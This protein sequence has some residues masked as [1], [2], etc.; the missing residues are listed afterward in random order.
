MLSASL[1][2]DSV[3]LMIVGTSLTQWTSLWRKLTPVVRI[4]CQDKLST[5]FVKTKIFKPLIKNRRGKENT[6]F[7]IQHSDVK[8]S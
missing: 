2:L 7:G 1:L 8:T 4:Q 3:A 5:V 6:Y